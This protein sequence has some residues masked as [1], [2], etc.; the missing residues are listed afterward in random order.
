MELKF[1]LRTLQ[2]LKA[3]LRPV[4]FCIILAL[5]CCIISELCLMIKQT[6]NHVILESYKVRNK[7]FTVVEKTAG[8]LCFLNSSAWNVAR[9]VSAYLNGT[10]LSFFE[11]ETKVAPILFLSLATIP[12]MSQVSYVGNDGLMFSYYK[13]KQKIIAVYSNT[14]YSSSRYANPVNRDTGKLYGDAVSSKSLMAAHTSWIPNVLNNKS[15]FSSVGTGWNED[16]DSLLLNAV[17]MD[18]RGVISLGFPRDAV[19]DHFAALDLHGGYFYL[20]TAEGQAIVQTNPEDTQIDVH[21][22]SATVQVL[23]RNGGPVDQIDL[24]CSSN[25][26][27]S[28]PL[29]GKLVGNKYM[30]YCSTTDI[31]GVKSVYVL[32]YPKNEL[33]SLV[34]RNSKLSIILLV[35]LF[36]FIV[37][38]LCIYIFLTARATK[39][40]MYL[41]AALIKQTEATQQAE[42]KSMNKTKAYAGAN[43]DVRG[44][45]AAITGLIEL[46]QENAKPASEL[47]AN[48]VQ[49]K[50]CTDDLLGIL[51]SILDMSKIEA[52]KASLERE[53]FNLAQLL[54][55]VVDMYYLL[56]MKKGVD[57]VLDPCDGSILKLPL[58][59]GD[60]IKLKQ[61]L[62]NL[63][64]NAI[65]FTS[66]GHISVRAVVKKNNFKKEIIASNRTTALKFLSRF[67]H[68]NDDAFTD[69]DALQTV[70][71]NPNEMEIEFEVDDTGKG[72]PRDKQKSIFEDY[73]QVKETTIGQEGCGLGLGIVQSL[74]RVMKGELSIVEKEF[75][76]RGTCFRFNVFLSIPEP[77]SVETEESRP[78]A[79]HQHFTFISPK[80]EGSHIVMFIA[81]EERRKVLKKYIESLNIKVTIIK[82]GRHFRAEL[83]KVKPSNPDTGGAS[84]KPQ[85]MKDGT[86]HILPQYKKTN[87]KSSSGIILFV[88][89]NA[90]G[91]FSEFDYTLATFRRD[92]PKSS[93]KFVWLDDQMIRQSIYEEQQDKRNLEG[94]YVIYKPFHGSR[95]IQVL[96]LLPERKGASQCNFTRPAM[97][98]T[99]QEVRSSVDLNLSN[100]SNSSMIEF[101]IS[102]TSHPTTLQHVMIHKP[103]TKQKEKPLNGKKVLVVEDVELLRRLI[104]T[105]LRKLGANVEVCT[106]GEEALNQVCRALSDQKKEGD[107]KC[108]P[109]DY[110]F[111]D[112]EMPVMN[113][114]EATRLIRMEEK[115]Y[116]VH[117][118]VIALTA[119]A[120][121]E[122]ASK[123]IDAGMDFHL[124][125]PLQVDK[126]LDVIQSIDK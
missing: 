43:H 50:R 39:R 42:R 41:C 100:D 114:Y 31:A 22:S 6:K 104:T 101:D 124:T 66:E 20:A 98:S 116:D 105:S 113:G 51:N 102:A 112:C 44:S 17:A 55:D 75:G 27:K 2:Q 81:G 108:S 99:I 65:K 29:P 119:H 57:I 19:I 1:N 36:V 28:G 30:F 23:N 82:S 78:S 69:L 18:G 33:A 96:S 79:F 9:S 97:G 11:I 16:Q 91:N 10:Q 90:A 121:P 107:S 72:V 46:C 26:K 125:K 34:H 122:E 32:A 83:E 94:D 52:G 103:D 123:S 70:E 40:E 58:V 111:M 106:N 80:P 110:I 56:G 38:S 77:V 62:C 76:E 45:L 64:S 37:V 63:L 71:E 3:V 54:E 49:L 120:M 8:L 47:A 7:S 115:Q 53:D 93:C 117:I 109:Y 89:D 59:R 60:R 85:S 73:V 84:S 5:S 25:D 118:P 126:L 95:L 61:I 88:M 15:G 13:D 21:N 4:Y 68:R 86:D 67:C 87:S 92:I 14:S 74:V 12:R 48:L 35:I 24:Y